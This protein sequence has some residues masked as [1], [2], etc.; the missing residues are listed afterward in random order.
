MCDEEWGYYG[1]KPPCE[2][3]LALR[4]FL[5]DNDMGVYS[6]HGEGPMGWVNVHCEKCGRGY[7]VTLDDPWE[8]E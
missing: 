3:L 5:E 8:V 2:H 1:D 7:E 6:E 4:K